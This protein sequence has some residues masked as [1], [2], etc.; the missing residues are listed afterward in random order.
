MTE[1]LT[2]NMLTDGNP[3]IYW[4][5]ILRKILKLCSLRNAKTTPALPLEVSLDKSNISIVEKSILDG[6]KR[7]ETSVYNEFKI[8]LIGASFMMKLA[9]FQQSWIEYI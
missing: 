4:M 6:Y 3:L 9:S 1:G 5:Y 2:D 7:N 8:P